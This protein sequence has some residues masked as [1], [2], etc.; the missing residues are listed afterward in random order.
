MTEQTTQPENQAAAP[1]E[2]AA[3]AGAKVDDAQRYD[4][5][6]GSAHEADGKTTSTGGKSEDDKTTAGL[7]KAQSNAQTEQDN[8]DSD[9]TVKPGEEKKPNKVPARQ[10][11]GEL[12]R[13]Y[14]T[15]QAQRQKL[16]TEN[17]QL[18]EQLSGKKSQSMPDQKD[19]ATTRKPTRDDFESYDEY[20]D[21]LTDWKVDQKLKPQQQP[22]QRKPPAVE[23]TPEERALADTVKD[24]VAEG[25]DK[26][27][28]FA[29]KIF[30]PKAVMT[31]TMAETVFDSDNAVDMA[32]YFATHHDEAVKIA[33]MEPKA[34]IRAIGRLEAQLESG[35][36]SNAPAR[37]ETKKQTTQAP[38]PIEP[39]G[40]G[41]SSE[42]GVTDDDTPLSSYRAKRHKAWRQNGLA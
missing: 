17:Q 1:A 8:K 6:D 9:D 29:E 7:P 40:S 11:I 12:T 27:P 35:A 34:Q 32:Y 21:A 20:V 25:V 4:I 10:R 19:D 41:N 42:Y 3:K 37:K 15:E 36:V 38:E 23:I 30:D 18:K 22:D 24:V 16:E 39:E 28:D 2:P 33:R 13:Q 26:Y 5:D 31:Q 14:R